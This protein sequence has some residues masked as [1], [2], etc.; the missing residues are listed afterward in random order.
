MNTIDTCRSSGYCSELTLNENPRDQ[1]DQVDYADLSVPNLER[2]I[3]DNTDQERP[4]FKF[5]CC[6]S[7]V[8]RSLLLVFFHYAIILAVISFCIIFLTLCDAESKF[9]LG[10]LALLSACVG[11]VLPGPK[12]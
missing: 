3:F 9:A 12:R 5:D 8:E 2:I 10:V 6:D 11:H 1:Q 7:S 4:P